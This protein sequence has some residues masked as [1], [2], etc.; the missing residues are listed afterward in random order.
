MKNI[1]ARVC[2]CIFLSYGWPKAFKSITIHSHILFKKILWV[3]LG[4]RP[5]LRIWKTKTN[6]C[7]YFSWIL[8][9]G[10]DIYTT[11]FIKHFCR[12]CYSEAKLKTIW[13]NMWEILREEL[14]TYRKKDKSSRVTLVLPFHHKFRRIQLVILT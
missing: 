13:E 4:F 14:L 6:L 12:R 11:E 9:T 10:V 2:F 1:Y 5:T 7:R 3:L 8:N